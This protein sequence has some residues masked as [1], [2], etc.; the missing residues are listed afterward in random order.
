MAFNIWIVQKFKCVA[1]TYRAL[2]ELVCHCSLDPCPNPLL[3]VQSSLATE[4]L[5]HSKSTSTTRTL[6]IL[7]LL[8][9]VF[10]S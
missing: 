8:P 3:L 10:F 2:H 4:F 6:L 7:F 9:E 1:I 5:A